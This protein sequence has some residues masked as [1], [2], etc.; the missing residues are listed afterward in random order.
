MSSTDHEQDASGPWVTVA[1]L[2]RVRGNH[3]EITALA[4]SSRPERLQELREVYLFRDDAW[5]SGGAPFQVESAWFHDGRLI[6]KFLGVDTISAAEELQGAEVRIPRSER[7]ELPRGEYYE[8][9]LVGCEVVER[10]TG[11]VLGRVVELQQGGGSGLLMVATADGG[12]LLVPFARSIC[13]DIDVSARR[14]LV[15]LPEGL[16]EL[17]QK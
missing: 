1:L 10:G 13:T 5:L 9:D 8:S 16:K 4:F 14:I 6:L 17:N 3:G 11:N 15:D 7:P 2:G 12:E